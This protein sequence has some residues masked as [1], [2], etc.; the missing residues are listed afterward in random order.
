MCFKAVWRYERNFKSKFLKGI[1]RHAMF[2]WKLSCDVI[3]L[4]Q[5]EKLK[6]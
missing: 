6:I 4:L 3:T 1:E 2:V 5:L